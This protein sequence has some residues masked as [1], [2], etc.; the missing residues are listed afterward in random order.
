MNETITLDPAVERPCLQCGEKCAEGWYCGTCKSCP[1]CCAQN[2][3]HPVFE[4]KYDA[5]F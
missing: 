3:C 1:K 4:S 5:C 2:E